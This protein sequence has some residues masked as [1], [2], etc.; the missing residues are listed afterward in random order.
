[1][2]ILYCALIENL[3]VAA[4]EK[5]ANG[6]TSWT[7]ADA[8]AAEFSAGSLVGFLELSRHT[9]RARSCRNALYKTAHATRSIFHIHGRRMADPTDAQRL[10][11]DLTRE[12]TVV[13]VDLDA[14]TAR[15]EL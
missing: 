3:T 1:M 6:I 15:V 7:A 2:P 8:V 14:G 4:A 13:S 12:G 9:P 11:G 5:L 10:I